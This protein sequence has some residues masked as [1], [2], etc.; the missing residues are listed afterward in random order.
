VT[1][2]SH[3]LSISIKKEFKKMD[4]KMYFEPECEVIVLKTEGFLAASEPLEDGGKM[5]ISNDEDD[6][7]SDGF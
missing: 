6:N 1:G 3:P 5:P 2:E 7:E 4:K